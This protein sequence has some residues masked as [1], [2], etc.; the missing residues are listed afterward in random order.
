MLLILTTTHSFCRQRR[1]LRVRASRAARGGGDSSMVSQSYILFSGGELT[2]RLQAGRRRARVFVPCYCEEKGC[3]GEEIPTDTRDRHLA[4]DMRMASIRARQTSQQLS[5][6]SS[7]APSTSSRVPLL[8]QPPPRGPPT[9]N[10]AHSPT[11]APPILPLSSHNLPQ[12]GAAPLTAATTQLPPRVQLPASRLSAALEVHSEGSASRPDPR[13]VVAPQ[14]EPGD[15][16]PAAAEPSSST[17]TP[18]SPIHVERALGTVAPSEPHEEFTDDVSTLPDVRYE[19]LYL[20]VILVHPPSLNTS[21]DTLNPQ[22]HI[23]ALCECPI[24]FVFIPA[25]A[26]P[27]AMYIVESPSLSTFTLSMCCYCSLGGARPCHHG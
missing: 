4:L 8:P 19:G 26:V 5:A 22:R 17:P 21:T 16:I 14:A 25:D 11:V 10:T 18:P 2:R 12:L 24:F 15:T 20:L 7:A 23:A 13:D 6:V 1:G 3:N 27:V 9:A